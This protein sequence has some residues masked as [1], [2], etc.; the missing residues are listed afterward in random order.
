MASPTP[1]AL[2]MSPG[3][4]SPTSSKPSSPVPHVKTQHPSRLSNLLRGRTLGSPTE[5]SKNVPHASS[6]TEA[7]VAMQRDQPRRI[8]EYH[9]S[10]LVEGMLVGGQAHQLVQQGKIPPPMVK[11]KTEPALKYKPFQQVATLCHFLACAVCT[12]VGLLFALPSNWSIVW[13]LW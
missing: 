7:L 8:A 3:S 2:P 1:S 10:S 6:P 4:M 13:S 12:A 11:Q 9:R 5:S